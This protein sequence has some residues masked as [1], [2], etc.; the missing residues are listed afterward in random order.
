MKAK[1]SVIIP[2]YKVEKY[3]SRCVESV[4]NQTYRNLEIILVDDGSPDRCGEIC[5]D[6]AKKDSRITVVH[7]KNGGLSSARNAGLDVATGDYVGFIDSDDYIDLQMYEKLCDALQSHDA[8]MSICNYAYVAEESDSCQDKEILYSP[9]VTEV[10]TP[11]QAYQKIDPS[12]NGYS[13]YVT[14]WNKLYKR[15]LFENLRFKEGFINEDEFLVHHMFAQCQRIAVIDDV[16]YMYVQRGG[17]ITNVKVSLKSLDGVYA[18]YDRYAFFK[19]RG[20]QQ[21]ATASLRASFWALVTFLPKLIDEKDCKQVNAAVI[22]VLK[23]MILRADLRAAKLVIDWI[24]Y[25]VMWN[26]HGKRQ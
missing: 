5:D 23:S 7:K 21:L 26:L 15:G 12:W 3:L 25:L 2:I 22:M 17:S 1:I 10:L 20:N 4:M 19:E 14:A 11:E 8:D 16:L 24:R 18:F 13:F 9:I 6:Y